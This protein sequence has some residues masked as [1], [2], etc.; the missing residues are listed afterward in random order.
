[1]NDGMKKIS[2]ALLAV[3]LLSAT[4]PA[5]AAKRHHRHHQH[6]THRTA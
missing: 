3:V 5:F 6:H 2:L 1:M 4:S